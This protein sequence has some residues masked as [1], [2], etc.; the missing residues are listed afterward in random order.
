MIQIEYT[1]GPESGVKTF[2]SQDEATKFCESLYNQKLKRFGFTMSNL[3]SP[4]SKNVRKYKSR[5][6]KRKVQDLPRFKAMV[7]TPIK[8]KIT[9]L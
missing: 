8:V 9:H 5:E 6:L 3:Y 7:E 4:E 1:F 2:E